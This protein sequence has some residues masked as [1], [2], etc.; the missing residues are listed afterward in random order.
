MIVAPP[1]RNLERH[2]DICIPMY[3]LEWSLQNL[4]STHVLVQCFH[5][6]RTNSQ[7]G[8]L[9]SFIDTKEDVLEPDRQVQILAKRLVEMDKAFSATLHARKTRYIF[10]AL[11][12]LAARILI[13][14]CNYLENIDQ[15]TVQ[16]MCRNALSLQQTLSKG[17]REFVHVCTN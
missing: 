2:E 4:S 11:A 6:L 16:R 13:Q 9:D 10:E 7:N 14:A 17:L 1:P 12:H 8:R 15:V 5:Y 3:M